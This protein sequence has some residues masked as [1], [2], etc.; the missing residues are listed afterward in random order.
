MGEAVRG[1]VVSA[2]TM[3]EELE[4]LKRGQ[5]RTLHKRGPKIQ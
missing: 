3:S 2:R 5:E 1:I 4:A